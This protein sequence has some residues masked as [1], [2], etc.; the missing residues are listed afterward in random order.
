MAYSDSWSFLPLE[1]VSLRG[2]SSS[3]AKNCRPAKADTLR[4]PHRRISSS[5]ATW[6][7]LSH[8]TGFFYI[9]YAFH[10][11]ELRAPRRPMHQ[12]ANTCQRSNAKK[13]YVTVRSVKV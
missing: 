2:L 1:T 7:L 3:P 11:F 8:S 12:T 13:R 4:R 9:F 5:L 10:I 6:E